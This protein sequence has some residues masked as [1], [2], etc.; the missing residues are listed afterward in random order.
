LGRLSSQQQ[1]RNKF[2]S[3][4]GVRGGLVWLEQSFM[5]QYLPAFELPH[6]NAAFGERRLPEIAP[7]GYVSFWL[8]SLFPNFCPFQNFGSFGIFF[9]LDKTISQYVNR[10]SKIFSK[11]EILYEND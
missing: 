1:G 8:R 4:G 5:L 10:G 11:P 7:L 9:N 3:C 6:G 2:P